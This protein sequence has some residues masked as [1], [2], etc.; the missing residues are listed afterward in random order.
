[1]KNLSVFS[2]QKNNGLKGPL[3]VEEVAYLLTLNLLTVTL[4]PALLD[5]EAAN[6]VVESETVRMSARAKTAF[7]ILISSIVG[8]I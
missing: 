4:S 5:D 1:M 2:G 6:V 7:F 3:S 8:L